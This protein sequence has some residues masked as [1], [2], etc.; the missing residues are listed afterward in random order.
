MAALRFFSATRSTTPRWASR[1]SLRGDDHLANTP[2]QL[3]LLEALGTAAARVRSPAAAARAEWQ[4]RCRSAKGAASLTD[5]RAQGY[6]AGARSQLP[7]AARACLPTRRLARRSTDMAA[8][9]D[10]ARTSHSAARFDETQLRH[11]QRE[12]VT[13]ATDVRDR[14]VARRA[15]LDA[16]GD[17]P[18][19]AQ[20]VRRRR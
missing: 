6:F 20:R 9:F 5:L 13:R 19:C 3:L 11:W 17:E 14:A 12:A 16:L 15:R 8:H 18:Q 2:R 1:S 10:L 7:G 4:R